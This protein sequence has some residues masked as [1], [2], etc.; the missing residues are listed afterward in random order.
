[1]NIAGIAEAIESEIISIRRLIHSNP[2]LS[3]QEFETATLIEK[4]LS[5]LP[6]MTSVSRIGNTG[7]TGMLYGTQSQ[8]GK[9]LALRADIDALPVE[10]KTGL[11]FSSIKK[12]VMH[13]CGHDV[14]TAVLLGVA[15]VLSHTRD[16][17][18]GT[19]KFIFQPA[20]EN[21][22]GA[23]LLLKEGILSDPEVDSII[24]L[25]C[26]PEI[27]AGTV[28]IRRGA[29]MAAS[30]SLNIKVS[31]NQGHAAHPH[32]CVDPIMISAQIIT[33]IQTILSRELAPVEAAVVSFGQ[34]HG[35]H[36]PNIIPEMVELSGTVRTI[37]PTTRE[38]MP[39][40]IKR[41][42]E[43]IAR[44]MRG[45]ALVDYTFGC[46]PLISDENL[47]QLFERTMKSVL[48]DNV[49]VHLENPSMGSEDFAYYMEKVP[50]LFFRLGTADPSEP[51]V[52]L[53]SP[54]FKVNEKSIVTGITAMSSLAREYMVL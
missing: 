41:I 34:I 48:G 25:H 36:A 9:T 40:R 16:S 51:F 4:F 33:A 5:E 20:E 17:F 44:D 14:H 29:M 11:P 49:L 15:K 39:E 19:I 35:G 7:V 52:P 10:E 50:G 23:Q 21:L 27:P 28:A 22:A 6:G 43:G 2:E 3:L 1:M 24:G 53:H 12:G 42:S 31:G 54:Y 8:S 37:S 18:S 45:S 30:D 46:P 13:A 38:S 26:W 32:K 47:I